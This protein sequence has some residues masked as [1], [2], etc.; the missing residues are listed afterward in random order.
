MS[1]VARC[2]LAIS[3]GSALALLACAD[4]DP[5]ARLDAT[6]L[7]KGEAFQPVAE[8]MVDRCGSL[9]CHGSKY[10][11]MRLFGFGGARLDPAD[12]PD[13]PGRTTPAESDRD[14]DTIVS[15]EP[16]ILR[17]VAADHGQDPERLTFIRKGRNVEAHKGGQRLVPGEDADKCIT[18]WLAGAV[19]ANV[20]KA[21][22]AKP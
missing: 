10:R 3:V 16:E 20:C 7:P 15:V 2:I 21:A 8:V 19:D 4:D 13:S 1:R 14:Y 17:D 9:D 5:A 18:S 22:V 6:V 11:N 12:L